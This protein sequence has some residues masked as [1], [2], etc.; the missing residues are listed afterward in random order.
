MKDAIH[1]LCSE[2]QKKYDY[3][4]AALEDIIKEVAELK[5]IKSE[6][7]ENTISG[8]DWKILAGIAYN[9]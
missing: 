8:G 3:P 7:N 9:Q 1:Q 6:T 5:T 4:K 2:H